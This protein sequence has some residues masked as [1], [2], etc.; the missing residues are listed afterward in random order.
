MRG[1]MITREHLE[2]YIL[3][4][5]RLE[6]DKAGITNDIKDV[7]AAAKGD[8]FDVK[9]IKQI[10]KLRKLDKSDLEEQEALLELY[11][12]VLGV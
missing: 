6:E 3:R 1:Q 8:G 9:T 5:E 4:L 10:L 2:Q 7:T 12:S 11:R